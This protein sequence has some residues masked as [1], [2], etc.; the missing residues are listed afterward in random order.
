MEG[1]LMAKLFSSRQ[2]QQADTDW[3]N[4]L[5]RQAESELPRYCGSSCEVGFSEVIRTL[6]S[7]GENRPMDS[8]MCL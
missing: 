7:T 5:K 4:A 1:P 2:L 6:F 8:F 3:V